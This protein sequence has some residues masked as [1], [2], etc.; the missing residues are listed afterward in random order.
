MYIYMYISICV[1]IY[2]FVWCEIVYR[3]RGLCTDLYIYIAEILYIVCSVMWFR[4][5]K[6]F[7]VAAFGLPVLVTLSFGFRASD[8]VVFSGSGL[9][10][11]LT[12][13]LMY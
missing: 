3:S 12:F 13:G 9:A 7:G 6:G 4:N 10:L 8:T 5:L 2:G 11:V 1:Y